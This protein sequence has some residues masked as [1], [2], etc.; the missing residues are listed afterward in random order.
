MIKL[1]SYGCDMKN[2]K[3]DQE[4]V[5]DAYVKPTSKRVQV[6]IENDEIVCVVEKL[7]SMRALRCLT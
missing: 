4:T 6:N 5:I 1:E 3:N 7:R 2:Q